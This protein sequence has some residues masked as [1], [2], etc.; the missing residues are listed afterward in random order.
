MIGYLV[1]YDSTGIYRIYHPRTKTIKVSR[2]VVFSENEFFNG[3]HGRK[4]NILSI[5]DNIVDSDETNSVSDQTSDEAPTAPTIHD[6]IVVE[7]RVPDVPP[8]PTH[9]HGTRLTTE[10]LKLPNRRQRRAVAR[11][12]KAILKGSNLPVNYREAMSGDD[13]PQWEL[14]MQREYNSI[15]KNN[16][17]NLVPRPTDA[18]VVKSRWVLRMKDNGLHKARFCAKGFTQ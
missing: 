10:S 1:G 3:K 18:N 9:S 2:D 6:E 13:A 5:D 15:M 8:M 14:A 4:Q 7:P 16:T 11:A 12:F 17:W